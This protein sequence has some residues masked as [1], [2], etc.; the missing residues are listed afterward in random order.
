MVSKKVCGKIMANL[1]MWLFFVS[2]TSVWAMPKRLGSE[3]LGADSKRLRQTLIS[4]Y[5]KAP[6]DEQESIVDH[7]PL[8]DLPTE[9]LREMI[10]ALDFQSM[11]EFGMANKSTHSVAKT[12]FKRAL[13]E[14][15][16]KI[17]VVEVPGLSED[18]VRL[19]HDAVYET[20]IE[21]P[22]QTF[23]VSAEP[24]SA[25]LYRALMGGYPS[26]YLMPGISLSQYKAIRQVEEI[27]E[28]WDISPERPIYGADRDERH[29]FLERINQKTSRKFRLPTPAEE[30]Y[31][32]RRD[33]YGPGEWLSE[34]FFE[35]PDFKRF[36]EQNRYIY[37][38]A[39]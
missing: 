13:V 35:Q 7:V 24:I 6:R 36:C 20:A 2:S 5:F 22:I 4:D 27:Y 38:I 26:L 14:A 19:L 32:Q 33:Y 1:W 10:G 8:L 3:F 34:T 25:G 18:Q 23:R 29:E 9:L 15:I 11:I 21:L 30:E 37:L 39:L 17:E 16:E 12:A 28:S 31:L